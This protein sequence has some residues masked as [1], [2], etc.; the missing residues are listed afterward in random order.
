M[1]STFRY[2]VHAGTATD[3]F[4]GTGTLDFLWQGVSGTTRIIEMSCW[5]N[6]L[7]VR[8]SYRAG[9]WGPEIELDEDDPPIQIPHA[10]RQLEVR[11]AVAGNNSRYQIIG[12][13]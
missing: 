2:D 13:W 9:L 10:A 12:F 3:A 7:F 6:P 5:D 8:F 4:A 11:N 1:Q